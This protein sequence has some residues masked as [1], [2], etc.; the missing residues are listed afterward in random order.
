M[1]WLTYWRMTWWII[2][3]NKALMIRP[4]T[5]T[6]KNFLIDTWKVVTWP[7]HFTKNTVFERPEPPRQ[8]DLSVVLADDSWSA[9]AQVNRKF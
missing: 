9:R 3:Q 7:F 6:D 2:M 5:V 4:R 1:N 8:A